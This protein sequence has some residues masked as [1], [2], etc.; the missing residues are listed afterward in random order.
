[1]TDELMTCAACGSDEIWPLGM[2]GMVK[3]E[4]C[5][6]VIDLSEDADEDEDFI[7]IRRKK[8]KAPYGFD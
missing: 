1:M 2:T 6:D 4:D 5:G 3:C 8:P 7:P